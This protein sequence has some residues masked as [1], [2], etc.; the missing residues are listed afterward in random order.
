VT[1]PYEVLA[2]PELDQPV[3]VVMLQGWIDAG[4]GAA[5]AAG[6][7]DKQLDTKEVL[8]FDDDT[9][10]D[11]R[12]RRPLMELRD[13][14]N[15]GLTWPRIVLKAGKDRDGKDVLVLTGHEPDMG[16]RRFCDLVGELATRYGVRLALG[17]GAYPFASPHTRPSRVSITAGTSELAASLPYLKNSVDVPAG[18]EAA[19]EVHFTSL[20][21]PAVGLWAQ[22]PHYAANFPYPG[23]T[24]S[25]LA[26]LCDV[27]ELSLDLNRTMREADQH[28]A[29]LDE[30]VQGSDEHVQMLHQMEAAY[31]AEAAAGAAPAPMAPSHANDPLP[32]GDEIAAELERYL[33]DQ[34]NP[35]N[36]GNPTF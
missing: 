30:L 15:T 7:L 20:G 16:W 11:F 2:E 28:R 24:L 3:L 17:L 14:V 8:R 26:A 10:L 9:F 6:I 12:A 18:I 34:D 31:D 13:G 5:T 36:P 1:E 4:V 21:I 33:R 19:L 32:T 27:A 35:G 23:A 29:K 25:L 22:V